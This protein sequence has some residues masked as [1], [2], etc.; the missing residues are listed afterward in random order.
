MS[1]KIRFDTAN[2]PELPTIILARKNGDKIGKIDSR[3]IEVAGD[4]KEASEITFNINKFINNKKTPWWDDITD[5]KLVHCIEWD[6]WFEIKVEINETDETVKTVYCTQLGH[7]ELSQIKLYSTEINTENDIARDDYVTPT[8]FYDPD[9]VSSS[10]LHRIL[11][12]APHYTIT[13][14][15][16]SLRNIQ[17]V[18]TFDDKSIY[19]SFQEVSEEVN[20]L[21]VFPSNSDKN[22]KIQRTI[23]V[24]DLWNCCNDCGYRGDFEYE[25]PECQSKNIIEGYGEDTTIF[26]SADELANDLQCISDVDSVK[27]CF[28]LVAGDDL[29]TAT[30]INCNPN[31][32]DYLW[33][34]SDSVKKEMSTELVNKLTSYDVLYQQY[35]KTNEFDINTVLVNE[36][37]TLIDRYRQYN[38]TLQKIIFPIKGYPFL[39]ELYYN[40]I[41]FELYLQTGLMP[42]ASMSETNAELEA[43]KLTTANLSPV[44]VSNIN[45]LSVSSADSAILAMAKVVVDSRYKIKISNSFLNGTQWTGTFTVTNY[46]DEEDT[47]NVESI[48]VTINGDYETFIKQK[49]DKSLNKSE[50]EDLSVVGL[51][52]KEI[53]EFVNSL[54]QYSLD[55]LKIILSCCQGCIDVLIEQGISDEDTQQD[56]KDLYTALYEPY[57]ERK[58]A[59]ETEIQIRENEIAVIVGTYDTD[60]QVITQGIQSSIL[61]IRTQVQSILNFENYIGKDLWLELCSF[62][63]EDKYENSNYISDGLTNAELIYNANDFLQVAQKE[64][65][66][67]SQIQYSIKSTLKNL[68]VIKKFK[69]LVN[70]FKVGNWIRVRIDDTIYKL[71]LIHF[72]FNY[73]DIDSIN[74]EFSDVINISDSSYKVKKTLDSAASMASSYSTVKRQVK[75]SKE[76]TKVFEQLIKNGISASNI[77]LMNDADNQNQSWDKHGML[78]REYDETIGD[79]SPEQIKIINSTMAVTEDN[80][81]TS[82]AAIG[83][84]YF[85]DPETNE[86]TH[87]FG[88][89]GKLLIGEILLGKKVYI[90]NESGNLTF[91]DNGFNVTNGVNTIIINP[92][93]SSIFNISNQLEDILSFNENGNLMIVGDITAKSLTLSDGIKIQQNV[94]DGLPEVIDGLH[95]VAFSGEYSELDNRPNLHKV[96]TSGRYEDLNNRPDLSG[97][98]DNRESINNMLTIIENLQ[99]RI[100]MLENQINN[101]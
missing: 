84:V 44:A 83:K 79:Y 9:N 5:F 12:K 50:T 25:C 8:V 32:T 4:I 91:D 15:D 13:H 31:G 42:N 101:S 21:F 55:Y 2:R 11:E 43:S 94:I 89:N 54:K 52:K 26:A 27:N 96:A 29:M 85:V 71:R 48:K 93:N 70:H 67:A 10:L 7:A 45:S 87:G 1:I 39:M 17:R 75:Q 72:S 68:L 69:P 81:D 37:N 76:N 59:I 35:L 6:M 64:I 62:R 33:H 63:R 19:D 34:I 46:S 57:I 22:G 92:N 97:I 51:F 86:I 16:A 60:G 74:V 49:L 18:F 95:N 53:I 61:Y 40:T 78:F 41:D 65:L 23:E 3:A 100:I 98:E 99:E 77:S 80:W 14:V 24:Y 82:S 30:I 88:V 58:K 47:A 56:N 73:D 20:C 36:Y 66:K 28:K 90:K 38:D